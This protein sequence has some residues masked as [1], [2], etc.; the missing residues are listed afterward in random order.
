MAAAK[1]IKS[2][3][4]TITWPDG[5]KWPSGDAPTIPLAVE[6]E[7]IEVIFEDFPAPPELQPSDHCKQ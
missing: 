1:T 3:G 4:H 2:N 6:L 5:I 7:T